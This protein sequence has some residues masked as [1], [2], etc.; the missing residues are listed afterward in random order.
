MTKVIL[1][2]AR[3]NYPSP[4]LCR[5]LDMATQA[6]ATAPAEAST[7]VK[8]DFAET[9]AKFDAAKQALANAAREFMEADKRRAD[10]LMDKATK[11]FED[12]E[13]RLTK[14]GM[15]VFVDY[16]IVLGRTP[17]FYDDQYG[18]LPACMRAE[19]DKAKQET[20]LAHIKEGDQ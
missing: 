4:L 18:P 7:D 8:F 14:E 10:I 5:S 6:K 12:L 20:H 15:R 2:D 17:G 19:A 11:E 3:F 1:L 16:V 13:K 9:K